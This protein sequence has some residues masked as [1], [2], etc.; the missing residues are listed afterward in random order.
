MMETQALM[1]ATAVMAVL[2]GLAA[3]FDLK[4]LRIP[5][6]CVIAVVGLFIVT[7]LWGLPLD[8]FAWRFLHGVIA[9]VVGFGLYSISGG[10]V[11]GGDI[12]LIAA[13]TP[14]IAGPDVGRVLLIFVV[15]SF[16]GLLIHRFARGLLRD[17]KTGWAALDQKRFFPAG[18]L[19]GGTIMIYLGVEL[20]G[21]YTA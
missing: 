12:K 14:F 9:L 4:A 8:V 5:N 21:R 15:L 2:M 18:L 3:W 16:T 17:R 10:N 1:A 19:L 7:G 6:W 13:L 20:A 11:G